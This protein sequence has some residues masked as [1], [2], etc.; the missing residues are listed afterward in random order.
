MRAAAAGGA[1]GLARERAAPAPPAAGGRLS[2]DRGDAHAEGGRAR[3]HPWSVRTE[4]GGEA[5]G[6][7]QGPPA[8][9]VEDRSGGSAALAAAWR[10][11]SAW[12]AMGPVAARSVAMLAV[13]DRDAAFEQIMRSNRPP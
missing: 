12:P 9:P 2:R 7:W 10:T 13:S 1:C 4:I 8:K 5:G 11:S 6:D 3:T